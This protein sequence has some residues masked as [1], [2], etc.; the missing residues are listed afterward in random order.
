MVWVYLLTFVKKLHQKEYESI[1]NKIVIQRSINILDCAQEGAS[2][3]TKK[4]HIFSTSRPLGQNRFRGSWKLCL[5]LCSHKWLRPR[6]SF[7]RYLLPLLLQQ[8][9]TLFGDGLINSNKLFLKTLKLVALQ[10]LKSS[11]FHSITV[12][13]KK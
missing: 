5:N 10:R 6:C 4:M 9:K 11:L 2:L 7:V 3:I 8:L 12:D 13:G 1:L